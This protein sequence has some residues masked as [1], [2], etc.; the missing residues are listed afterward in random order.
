MSW[1]DPVC[2]IPLNTIPQTLETQKGK[3][4]PLSSIYT[5]WKYVFRVFALFSFW[6]WLFF[7]HK[8]YL[9]IL[10]S[11]S[12]WFLK[13]EVLS[14]LPGLCSCPPQGWLQHLIFTLL[15]YKWWSHGRGRAWGTCPGNGILPPQPSPGHC[16]RKRLEK[17]GKCLS[18]SSWVQTL[19]VAQATADSAFSCG[20][21][22]LT[23]AEIAHRGH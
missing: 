6:R 10:C 5:K 22:E 17:R 9:I 18:H 7:P 1:L 21:S 12:K 13:P 8:W 14:C 4:E 15:Y 11:F 20:Y 19:P 3:M 2:P 16:S 23:L